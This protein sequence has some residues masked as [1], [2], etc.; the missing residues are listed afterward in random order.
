MSKVQ[1]IV[2]STSDLSPEI[3]KNK[4]IALVPL[5]VVFGENE[6]KDGIEITTND[7]FEKVNLTGNLPKTSAP[8]P[9]DFYNIFHP[10]IEQGKDIIYIGLS[11]HLS[12]TVQNSKI[13][14]L[15]FPKD[16]IHIIDS[17]NLSSGIALLALQAADY[18]DIGMETKLIVKKVEEMVPKIQTFFAIDTLEYLQKGGRCSAIQS[19]IGNMLKIRPI[20]K[21]I[22]GKIILYEK[23]R[24]KKE[25][26]LDSLLMNLLKDKKKLDTSRI[27]LIHSLSPKDLE[28]LKEE[29]SSL[30]VFEEILTFEAGCV[31]SSHCGPKAVGIMYSTK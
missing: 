31:I 13:A 7:L 1:I 24:G 11:S 27:A 16:R 4:N 9:M 29:V 2:D 15:E 10:Y 18:A 21:V 5:Y 30:L 19:F 6:Y 23:V 12:A 14:A 17:L 28:Y 26:T 22:D 20:L 25:K 3:I 8:T